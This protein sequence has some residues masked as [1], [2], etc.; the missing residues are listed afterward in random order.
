MRN[1]MIYILIAVILLSGC[2]APAIP[3]Q[4]QPT[5]GATEPATQPPTA[6]PTEAPTAAPTAAPTEEPTEEPTEAPATEPTVALTIPETLLLTMTTEEKVGQLFLARCPD[7][8]AAEDAA[9]YHL[10][11]YVLF[12]RD[13][14]GKD[15]EQVMA[16][17]AAYQES[18]SI[19]MLI[20][21]DEEGGIV[22]RVSSYF[23]E[24]RFLSP[25]KLYS[26]GGVDLILSTETEKIQLLR[27]FGI[28][29]NL[30]P[31][32]D[33]TTDPDA[34]MYSRSLGLSPEETG[35]V[36]GAMVDLMNQSRFGAVL[37]HFPGYG[38]NTDT[39]VGIAVDDRTLDELEA[40]DLVPFAMGIKAG[41][42]AIMVSH[43]FV[44]CLDTELPAS[45]SPKVIGYLRNDMGFEG[46]IVTDDLVMQA[47]TDLYGAGES[48]VLAVL[49]GNDLLCSSEYQI[50]YRAVLE[51]VEDGR[52]SPEM[53][54][55]AVLRVL[56]WKY[57][58][59]L[60]ENLT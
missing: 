8:N 57:S 18:A 35:S 49:A 50:Q 45:L 37:K 32:C 59:G 23:R 42:G 56:N 36:I 38:N 12:G 29:V 26:Q 52:I 28:N 21:V 24:S 7:I 43:T 25:R 34:F 19:P 1:S 48:A 33:V 3:E 27:S 22:C 47:I 51:A 39:H 40:N 4:T 46:V 10:G 17:I 2:A 58:L 41:A 53:L 9:A 30:A 15:R 60:L 55:A 11:G 6:E 14:E 13:F 31:V 16:D 20:A 54:D 44:N 5:S